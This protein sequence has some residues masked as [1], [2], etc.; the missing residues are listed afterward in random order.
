MALDVI[1]DVHGQYDKLVPLLSHLGY[2]EAN[3][4]W[5]HPSRTA[6]F[7]GDLIDRGP[8]QLA[9]VALVRAMV[10]AGSAQCI[11]GNHEFN[12]GPALKVS[13]IFA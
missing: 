9:T 8:K 7:L 12:A 6:V 10:E 3:G 13:C 1:G 5:R 2:S 4:A 11:L